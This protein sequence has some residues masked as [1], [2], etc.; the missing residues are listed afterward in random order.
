MTNQAHWGVLIIIAM[1]FTKTWM[2]PVAALHYGLLKWQCM[3][4]TGLSP[5]STSDSSLCDSGECM[6][7]SLLFGS[8]G[9][10]PKHDI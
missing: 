9:L 4:E 1:A 2:C 8:V 5:S 7:K 6:N 10:T 3:P